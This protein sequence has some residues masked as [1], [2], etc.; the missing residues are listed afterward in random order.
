MLQCVHKTTDIKLMIAISPTVHFI[1]TFPTLIEEIFV[2]LV[3][4][5]C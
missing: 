5:L 4:D 1:G 3:M 2:E